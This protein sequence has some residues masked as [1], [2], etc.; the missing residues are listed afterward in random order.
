M[1]NHCAEIWNSGDVTKRMSSSAVSRMIRA[2]HQSCN[3]FPRT[4]KEKVLRELTIMYDFVES[5]KGHGTQKNL[6][7]KT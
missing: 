7:S 3:F 6:S 4:W 5:C 1:V 2:R